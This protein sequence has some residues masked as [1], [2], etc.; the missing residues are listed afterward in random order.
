MIFCEAFEYTFSSSTDV[1][2]Y[3]FAHD[4][5]DA[6]FCKIVNRYR[7][8]ALRGGQ[9]LAQKHNSK[10]TS[11][12]KKPLYEQSPQTSKCSETR[13]PLGREKGGLLIEVKE[14]TDQIEFVFQTKIHRVEVMY[15]RDGHD[16]SNFK[17]QGRQYS[18][19]CLLGAKREVS[20]CFLTSKRRC[21]LQISLRSKGGKKRRVFTLRHGDLL[22]LSDK[23][24]ASYS[25]G[26][27]RYADASS[28]SIVVSFYC[29]RPFSVDV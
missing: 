18:F 17:K 19:A 26:I 2:P 10:S 11:P 23:M 6:S 24:T 27:S 4:E 21:I 9:T 28:E 8:K 3:F 1:F 12:L 20:Q 14:L 29:D 5:A 25:Q 16:F 15:L 7:R 13:L 22:Y